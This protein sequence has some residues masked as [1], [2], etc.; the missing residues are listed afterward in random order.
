MGEGK[1][2]GRRPGSWGEV[3]IDNYD[4]KFEVL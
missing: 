3:K 4:G 2:G 1:R